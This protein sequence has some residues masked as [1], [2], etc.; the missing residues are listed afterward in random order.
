MPTTRRR[1]VLLATSALAAVVGVAPASADCPQGDGTLP[2]SPSS[3][4][5]VGTGDATPYTTIYVD[6]RDFADLDN[7]GNAQSVWLYLESN[8]TAGLQRGGDQVAMPLIPRVPWIA[9]IPVLPP[10][11]GGLPILP[12]GLTLFP[13]GFGCW[14]CE[15]WWYDDCRTDQ[16]GNLWTGKPDT[17]LI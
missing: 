9:P 10:N 16:S 8:G 14:G 12:N 11:P 1:L 5:A 2:G 3:V 4:T 6:D 13:N 7:D 17:L 15:L